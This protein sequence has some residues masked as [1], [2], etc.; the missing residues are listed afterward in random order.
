[1]KKI[2][3]VVEEFAL[4]TPAQQLLDRFLLGY[5]RDGEFHKLPEDCAVCLHLTDPV[6]P[7]PEL[8]RRS[9][10]HRLLSE[11]NLDRALRS[12]EAVIVVGRGTGVDPDDALIEKVISGC[13]Q[14]VC[15]FVHGA[16]G[17]TKENA[18][19]HA[20]LAQACSVRL[21]AGTTA[22][23]LK[24]LPELSMPRNVVVKEA[25]IVVQGPAP[26][27]EMEGFEALL[28]LVELRRGGEP[29]VQSVKLL[30]GP[31]LWEGGHAGAWSWEL[32]AAALSR[33]DSP[34]GE[35][36]TDGR[37]QD[38]IRLG[39]VPKLAQNPRG[40][41]IEHRDGLQTDILVLDGVV[42]DYNLAMRLADGTILST[43]L[44]RAPKPQQQQ[45]S[46][47]TTVLEDFF[48]GAEPPWHPRRNILISGLIKTFRDASTQPGLRLPTPQ[49]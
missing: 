49:L 2:T 24:R 23:V 30:S 39:L 8:E 45:F 26:A 14:G 22:A 29:G 27:A 31:S 40:W 10:E 28:P 38:L 25:L 41:V 33:S 15:C 4:G 19:R 20:E 5:P 47:L 44:Y 36:V 12:A 34:Q 37:T 42:A 11:P 18:A 7:N 17:S 16:L 13:E 43:Q 9:K 32:L 21:V 48:R 3:F 46:W 6:A 1:L 35:S